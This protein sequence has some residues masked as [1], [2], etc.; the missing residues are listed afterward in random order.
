MN[1]AEI[2]PD[3]GGVEE[4]VPQGVPGCTEEGENTNTDWDHLNAVVQIV[5]NAEFSEK[6]AKNVSR[7]YASTV[8]KNSRNCM[9]DNQKIAKTVEKTELQ[10]P[11]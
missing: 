4:S 3:E 9:M 6:V 10:S 7:Q 8:Q 2:Q 5:R 1:V 11:H